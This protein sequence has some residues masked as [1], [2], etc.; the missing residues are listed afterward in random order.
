M[1]WMPLMI[2]RNINIY[3]LVEVMKVV[4]IERV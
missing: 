1:S 4:M 2:W 3:L